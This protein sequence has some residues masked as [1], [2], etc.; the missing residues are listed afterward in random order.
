MSGLRAAIETPLGPLFGDTRLRDVAPADRI[1]ELGFELPLVGGDHPTAELDVAALAG[2]L[3]A[4]VGSDDPLAGY[5]DRLRDPA[6]GGQL[7]GYLT[8]SLDWSC[9]CVTTASR[10]SPSS[11]TR[12]TGSAPRAR[13]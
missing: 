12:P 4:H 10:G 1:D 9:G 6:F 3:D 7:R 5:A 8:G 11:T 2:V 13:T